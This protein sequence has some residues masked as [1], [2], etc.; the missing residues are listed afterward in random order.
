MTQSRVTGNINHVLVSFAKEARASTADIRTLSTQQSEG[1][2]STADI[3]SLAS[4]DGGARVTGN[5]IQTLHRASPV[6][7]KGRQVPV[8]VTMTDPRGI[9]GDSQWDKVKF[10]F[11]ATHGFQDCSKYAHKLNRSRIVGPIVRDWP[12]KYEGV[13]VYGTLKAGTTHNPRSVVRPPPGAEADPD[14]YHI[15]R[16]PFCIEAWVHMT[17]ANSSGGI[18][19][20][21]DTFRNDRGW[22]LLIESSRPRFYA[23]E[24][25]AQADLNIFP[26]NLIP[27][28][29]WTHI[30]VERDSDNDVRIYMNGTMIA[31]QNSNVDIRKSEANLYLFGYNSFASLLD[32]ALDDV[33]VTIGAARYASDTGFTPNSRPLPVGPV[34]NVPETPPSEDPYWDLVSILL[35]S[36]NAEMT[37]LSKYETPYTGSFSTSS[38]GSWGAFLGVNN[39][40]RYDFPTNVQFTGEP[41][42][43][44]LG[45]KPFTFELDI[46][47]NSTAAS[48]YAMT[49]S[50][51]I[52]VVYSRATIYFQRWDGS[53]WQTILGTTDGG[54]LNIYGCAISIILTYD[55]NGNYKLF[56]NGYLTSTKKDFP[57]I[58]ATGDVLSIQGNSSLAFFQLRITNGVDR[59]GDTLII[60][61]EDNLTWFNTSGPPYEP[62][63]LPEP[64]YPAILETDDPYFLDPNLS[65]WFALQGGR[66][67]RR[68]KFEQIGGQGNIPEGFWFL[69]NSTTTY[70]HAAMDTYIPI[71]YME[72][73]GNALV[74]VRL[75]YSSAGY[76]FGTFAE[77][78]VA[79][80]ALNNQGVLT[81]LTASEVITNTLWK[82][83]SLELILP[84]DTKVIRVAFMSWNSDAVP[85]INLSPLTLTLDLVGEVYEFPKITFPI[86]PS[87]FT[88]SV[89]PAPAV[90]T[91]AGQTYY[92]SIAQNAAMQGEYYRDETV[93]VEWEG[94]IDSGLVAL[95]FDVFTIATS[96]DLVDGGRSWVE[97]YDGDDEL[98]WERFTSRKDYR[99]ASRAG[100]SE[101]L[102]IRVPA[103][104]RKIRY[105]ATGVKA[106]RQAL[107]NIINYHPLTYNVGL[108]K[109]AVLPPPYVPPVAPVGDDH[110]DNVVLLLSSR[111]GVIENLQSV[112]LSNFNIAGAA[113]VVPEASMFDDGNSLNIN[114]AGAAATTSYVGITLAPESQIGEEPFT[115]EMWIKKA[116]DGSR[117]NNG[118]FSSSGAWSTWYESSGL[119][120]RV[121]TALYPDGPTPYGDWVHFALTRTASGKTNLFINGSKQTRMIE[122]EGAFPT[123]FE[124]GRASTSSSYASWCGYIDEVRLTKG[125]VR[126]TEDFVPPRYRFPLSK[127]STSEDIPVEVN[128]LDEFHIFTQK[129]DTTNVRVFDEFII[130]K[131]ED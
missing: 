3:R 51:Q 65:S 50:S 46:I 119:P 88:A 47:F 39:N 61:Q 34:A 91:I 129:D 21:Y 40:P 89:G 6:R 45:D 99:T 79:L 80:I 74:K 130:L 18:I 100:D 41:G 76:D 9:A 44:D 56:T 11:S 69:A 131:E 20:V 66:P 22:A 126:Y 116:V 81:A 90:A 121:A 64:D 107:A 17:A 43:F 109:P 60:P 72:D 103:G 23:S 68:T 7:R 125:V 59:Y 83:Q 16:R 19:G 113:A 98:L 49:I 108:T 14:N 127:G 15:G 32:G 5:I 33:R 114:A 67:T 27:I 62:V 13:P 12:P 104:T 36:D 54:S 37:D 35:R 96:A 8:S 28:N 48:A 58:P 78:G 128:S 82:E 77:G 55:G 24:G 123:S 2:V 111:N 87:D 75:D 105:G 52:R 10:L 97:F 85:G 102:N 71:E 38:G 84:A 92:T 1:R 94:D 115:Y 120:L 93:P 73:I 29:I 106:P 122:N 95:K 101:R 4:Y 124:I 110:W 25:N 86:S 70:S 53:A 26:V 42:Q 117:A 57:L 112:A 30:C 118:F 63:P 31:K